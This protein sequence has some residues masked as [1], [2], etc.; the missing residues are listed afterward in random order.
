MSFFQL[1]FLAD[2]A[3]ERKDWAL[4]RRLW[5]KWSPD[6]VL[7]EAEWASRRA[8]FEE[9]GVKK[10][11]LSYYRQNVNLGIA[12][13]L[14]RSEAL[15]LKEIPV[16][17]LAMVG[18]DDGCLDTRLFDATFCDD[19]FPAGLERIRMDAAGHFMHLDQ[20]E[21]VNRALLDW[22]AVSHH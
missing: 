5:S 4:L 6:L 20:P 3:V 11:M 8:T 21:L 15:K 12:L 14:V 2:W 18:R 22:I 7:S 10:V 19:D 1:R 13:G 17:T 16:R 9:P